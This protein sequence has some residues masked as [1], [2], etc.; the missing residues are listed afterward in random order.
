[1]EARVLRSITITLLPYKSHSVNPG[2]YHSA[3]ISHVKYGAR[4]EVNA[5]NRCSELILADCF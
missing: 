5:D 4:G 2:I 3:K 1:M